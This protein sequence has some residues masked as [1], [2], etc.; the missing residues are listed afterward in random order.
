MIQEFSTRNC[1]KSTN[2]LKTYRY[3]DKAASSEVA[4]LILCVHFSGY[5]HVGWSDNVYV[6]CGSY[7]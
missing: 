3:D 7:F 6:M 2:V 4:T 1:S 5:V